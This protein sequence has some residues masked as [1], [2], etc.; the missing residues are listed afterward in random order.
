MSLVNT[1]R[2]II[3]GLEPPWCLHETLHR[4][5]KEA[6]EVLTRMS[7]T[8]DELQEALGV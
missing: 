3:D 8:L 7:I 4:V 1:L 2:F 5:P 6:H